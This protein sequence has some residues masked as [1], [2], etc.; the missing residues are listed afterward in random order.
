M[1]TVAFFAW[2]SFVVKV[3][4]EEGKSFRPGISPYC[5]VVVSERG[6]RSEQCDRCLIFT[7]LF[8]IKMAA[9]D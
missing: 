5:D 1:P 2:L 7:S 6:E 3:G 9:A 4:I 8:A